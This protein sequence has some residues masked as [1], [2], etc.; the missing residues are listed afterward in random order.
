LESDRNVSL[1]VEQA[2]RAAKRSSNGTWQR[3]ALSREWSAIRVTAEMLNKGY[4]IYLSGI[5][6]WEDSPEKVLANAE[7]LRIADAIK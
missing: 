3:T 4:G 2:H 6:S 7:R 1:L 5:V